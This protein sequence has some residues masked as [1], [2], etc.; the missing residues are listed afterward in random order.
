MVKSTRV[1]QFVQ[2]LFT[3]KQVAVKASR[4]VR[5]I[6]EAQSARLTEIARMMPGSLAAC[7]KELQRFVAQNDAKAGLLR[8]LQPEATFV[9][10]D[11]TEVPRRQARRTE[12]VGKLSDGKT[13]G[14]WLLML[15]TPF[16]GRAIPF[17]FITYSSKTIRQEATSRNMEH[18][19]AFAG[20]K[21]VL[22]D[23][24]LILDREFSYLELLLNLAAEEA[25]FVIR[26]NLGSHPPVMLSKTGQRIDLVVSPGQTVVY[27]DLLYK[28][29]VRVQVI[30]HW[31]H[32]FGQP[33]W[34][35]T[36]LQPEQALRLYQQRMKIEESFRDLKNLLGLDRVMNQRRDYLEQILALVMIAY[37][38]GLLLGESL[39]DKLFDTTHSKHRLYSG[40]F[41]LL[42]HRPRVP[43]AMA[44]QI[45]STA[46]LAF[47]SLVSAPV[48]THV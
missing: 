18:C 1:Q 22:G 26:L 24:P 16:Q 5:A 31:Q 47:T 10:G 41:L 3:R 44:Q 13:R 27:R 33:L 38:I 8:L 9:I 23:R 48:R 40:L 39:R 37:A 30:G 2:T 14:F 4:I 42:E 11:V 15:A 46:L 43:R 28:E 35:I 21:A 12:Y 6:L 7:Y 29:Q 36:D 32:G 19:R 17:H 34:L 20:I 25:H 45:A